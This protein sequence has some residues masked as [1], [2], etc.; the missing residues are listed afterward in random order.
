M[1][2]RIDAEVAEHLCVRT[3]SFVLNFLSKVA[4][5]DRDVYEVELSDSDRLEF[6]ILRTGC[7]I[8]D[9]QAITKWNERYSI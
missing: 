4:G 8:V 5:P 6:F 3:A 9:P 7:T 2:A 1:N